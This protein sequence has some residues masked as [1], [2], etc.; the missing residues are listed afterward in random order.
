MDANRYFYLFE[1]MCDSRQP[2]LVEDS[3]GYINVS[4]ASI[5]S[6]IGEKFLNVAKDVA[7]EKSLLAMLQKSLLR[8]P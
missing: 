7:I 4:R 5:Q 1:L 6:L 3:L 8:L 2:Q